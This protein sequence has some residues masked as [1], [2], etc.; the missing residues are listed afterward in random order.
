MCVFRAL[1]RIGLEVIEEV[2]D[3]GEIVSE[4]YED[5]EP[6]DEFEGQVSYQCSD[7]VFI[8]LLDGGMTSVY[9]DEV[10]LVVQEQCD[11]Y[12]FANVQHTRP[13][14]RRPVSDE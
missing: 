7:V 9:V 4:R 5:L 8:T 6:G 14:R 13:H 1:E 12:R 11:C 2:A 10:E 3:D